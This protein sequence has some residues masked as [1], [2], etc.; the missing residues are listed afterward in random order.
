MTK[1]IS[2]FV[3]L[4]ISGSTSLGCS[5]LSLHSDHYPD[6]W[7][8]PVPASELASWE[9][10]PQAA[11][12]SKGE[13]I[14]SKKTELGILSN[15][16]ATPFVLDGKSYASVEGFWQMM[17][18]PEGLQDPRGQNPKIQWAHTREQVSRLSTFEAKK[19]GDLANENMK[20]LGI[21]WIS[22]QGKRFEPKTTD[23][24]FHYQLI[25]RASEA[26]ALQN[27]EVLN[28]LKRT[29]TLK[30][31]PDHEQKPDVTPAYKYFEIQMKIREGIL[32]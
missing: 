28:L 11:D 1:R 15:F 4:L 25:Y 5:A 9:I 12:R 2:F 20:Q 24:D 21:T 18:Y 16:A 8:K 31:R 3:S 30:L 13:V 23:A 19:A 32:G 7:W 17:K 22:Y 14:L 10:P 29:G 27:P 26:K 6:E